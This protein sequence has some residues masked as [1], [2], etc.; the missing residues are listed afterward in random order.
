MID[1]FTDEYFFLSNFYECKV[2]YEGITYLNNEAAFQSMKTLDRNERRT[3][4]EFDPDAAKKAGRKISLR[5]DWE[6]IKTEL[7]YEICK[8]KFTQNN[9]LAAK[10]L[11]TGDEELVEGNNW[12]D[13]IWGKVNGQGE[14][15]LGIIL[16]RIR[17]ELRK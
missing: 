14:N 8:A 15:R 7:M 5:S 13:K 16:M 4:A 17:E 6:D 3:F 12:N 1:K 9:D 10:L 11:A 2:T